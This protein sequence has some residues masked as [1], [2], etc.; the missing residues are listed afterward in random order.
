MISAPCVRNSQ[1]HFL[2]F[3]KTLWSNRERA[4]GSR[5][6][7]HCLPT[8]CSIHS[9]D[10]RIQQHNFYTTKAHFLIDYNPIE[11]SQKNCSSLSSAS[12]GNPTTCF[13]AQVE[14]APC[15]NRLRTA[16]NEGSIACAAPATSMAARTSFR[17]LPVL[18]TTI[19]SSLCTDPS[20]HAC[21]R[22]A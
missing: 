2:E 20:R 17:P 8:I 22:P 4:A 15:S 14:R 9:I 6:A 5:T 7:N 18:M 16:A 11:V 19:V 1:L 3:A 12:C 10:C 13:H 21:R